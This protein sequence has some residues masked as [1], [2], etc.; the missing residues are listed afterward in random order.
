MGITDVG[1][2]AVDIPADE[3]GGLSADAGQPRKLLDAVRHLPAVFIPQHFTHFHYITCLCMIKAAASYHFLH[4]GNIGFCKGIDIRVACKQRRHH[5]IDPC[6]GALCR[7][8][9]SDQQLMWDA[10]LQGAKVLRV[11][12][13]QRRNNMPDALFFFHFRH[14]PFPTMI[15]TIR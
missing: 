1:G 12:L 7:Q 9:H 10:V 15:R 14:A 2:L 8:P 4:I 3:V 5:H 11:L 13:F 6:I